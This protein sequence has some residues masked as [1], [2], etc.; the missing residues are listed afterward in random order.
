[1]R[2]TATRLNELTTWGVDPN[3]IRLNLRWSPAHRLE[4]MDGIIQTGI[5][6]RQ[7]TLDPAQYPS[8]TRLHFTSPLPLLAALQP[9]RIV[10]VGRLAGVLQGVPSVSY[11]LDLC[12]AQDAATRTSLIAALAPFTPLPALTPARLSTQSLSEIDTTLLRVRLFPTV[13]GIG[14]YAAAKRHARRLEIA[15]IALNVLTLPALRTSLAAMAEPD[16]D[17]FIPWLEATELLV[18]APLAAPDQP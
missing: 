16:D 13:P 1:M 2:S 4:I 6:L 5:Q 9:L 12:Y 10:G 3:L 7:Q 17:F 15:E 8:L 14:D 18:R 11:T